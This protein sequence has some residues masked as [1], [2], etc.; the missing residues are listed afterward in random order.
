MRTQ[1]VNNPWGC[2]LNKDTIYLKLKEFW[3]LLGMTVIS[4]FVRGYTFR[5]SFLVSYSYGMHNPYLFSR[6]IGF[7]GYTFN[8]F[9][10]IVSF[11]S[12]YFLVEHIF[13]IGY[14]L[15][16][17]LFVVSLYYLSKSIFND[18]KIATFVILLTILP[19][20]GFSNISTISEYFFYRDIAMSLIFFSLALLIRKRYFWAIFLLGISSFI[21]IL[22]T[23]YAT[24]VVALYFFICWKNISRNEKMKII[25]GGVVLLIMLIIPLQ[26]SLTVDTNTNQHTLNEWKEVVKL[27]AFDHYFLSTFYGAG[28][29][30]FFPFLF[31]FCL[32]WKELKKEDFFPSQHKKFFQ[33]VLLTAIFCGAVAVFV[34]EI[35]I[36]KLL[37]SIQMFRPTIFI[38]ILA[39]FYIAC[40]M[41]LKMD[42]IKY[43]FS[44][45]NFVYGL[46][47]ISLFWFDYRLLWLCLIIIWFLKMSFFSEKITLNLRK[48]IILG[49]LMSVLLLTLFIHLRLQ[50]P[51]FTVLSYILK[52][53]TF[54][55]IATTLLALIF[56]VGILLKYTL[57]VDV[58]RKRFFWLSVWSLLIIISVIVGSSESTDPC[59]GPKKQLDVLD[60]IQLPTIYSKTNEYRL[61]IW[62]KENT[63][64]N[65]LF[66]YPVECGG[67]RNIAQRSVFVDFKYG[68]LT[69]Y[70]IEFSQEWFDRVKALNP[71]RVNY[72]HK[73]F[74]Q[75]FIS[76][77]DNLSEERVR[78]LDEKYDIDYAVFKKE[79]NMTFPVV[80]ENEEY[81]VY[82]LRGESIQNGIQ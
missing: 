55:I 4:L 51:L 38:T 36:N 11:L 50:L 28:I 46:L 71:G 48:M 6:D 23:F 15:S 77:Y 76:D 75:D 39:L 47:I 34:S 81:V 14:L 9:F 59:Y 44:M 27:R 20:P 42:E 67:F 24:G 16:S 64:Q 3:L 79:K 66:L 40:R 29:I 33:A 17:F 58:T 1:T 53:N 80:Y 2:R 57:N 41:K 10:E 70:S 5:S 13:F 60:H 61:A 43:F 8:F 78:L 74:Y 32:F 7:F 12:N 21:H 65:S 19:K 22:S 52:F 73:T 18:K 56:F 72:S 68:V 54:S 35:W 69:P 49:V 26:A 37:L 45:E 25:L 63:L 31:F 62:A 30:L 82:D